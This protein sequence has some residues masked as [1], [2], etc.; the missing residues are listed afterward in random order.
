MGGYL[1]Q[2]DCPTYEDDTIKSRETHMEFTPSQRLRDVRLL[3]LDPRSPS[4][5]I[6]RTPIFVNKT[7]DV[8]GNKLK[9]SQRVINSISAG[10][11]TKDP[12]SPTRDFTRT[13]INPC[14]HSAA[15]RQCVSSTPTSSHA[16]CVPSTPTTSNHVEEPE[17]YLESVNDSPVLLSD[18]HLSDEPTNSLESL[19][20]AIGSDKVSV[21]S[22]EKDT[23]LSTA[24]SDRDL[25]VVPPLDEDDVEC[26]EN[27]E[28][29]ED[30]EMSSVVLENKAIQ[31]VKPIEESTPKIP[32]MIRSISHNRIGMKPK[33][34]SLT[35]GITRS[36]L[37]TVVNSPRA[38]QQRNVLPHPGRKHIRAFN[39]QQDKENIQH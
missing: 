18:T 32:V 2:E 22:S 34:L 23:S 5:F 6:D 1:S 21:S 15:T 16:E 36:P 4:A 19:E 29:Y 7:P 24:E 13:P 39:V 11:A 9:G 10:P 12:R 27:D 20:S 38:L 8:M 33:L 37:S 14:N 25:L 28:G 35:P 26:E 3:A 17:S 31:R 30:M